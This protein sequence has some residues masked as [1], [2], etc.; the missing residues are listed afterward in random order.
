MVNKKKVL[1]G[2]KRKDHS[3]LYFLPYYSKLELFYFK[4][5]VRIYTLVYSKVDFESII[6]SKFSI[7]R[8]CGTFWGLVHIF[9]H[10]T[11]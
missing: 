6:Q 1:F 8:A 7:G 10:P 4:S 11:L 9:I 2:Q 3:Y 5:L